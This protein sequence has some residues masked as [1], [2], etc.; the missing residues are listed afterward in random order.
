M[1]AYIPA[2]R[3]GENDNISLPRN[4]WV[5]GPQAKAEEGTKTRPSRKRKNKIIASYLP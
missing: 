3:S 1:T 4:M 2:G 5:R